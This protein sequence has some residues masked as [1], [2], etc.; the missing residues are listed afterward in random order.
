MRILLANE[1]RAGGGGVETYLA[2]LAALLASRGHEVALLHDNTAREAGPTMIATAEHW[3][4]Q[5]DGFDA[6]LERAVEW[7]PDVCFSHN[8]RRLALDEA[9]IARGRVVKMMHGYF[10]TCVSGQKAFGS[11]LQPCARTCGPSCL[12]LYGPRRCGQLRPA[13]IVA[14]YRWAARQRRLF[15]RYA[16]IVVASEHMRG[17][18]LRHGVRSG[19][20]HTIPLFAGG[21]ASVAGEPDVDVVFLGRLTP[22]KGGETLLRAAEAAAR[23]IGRRVS[24]VMAGSGPELA[25]L[26]SLSRQLA[27]EVA[28]PGWIGEAARA[29]LLARAKVA[30]LPS[31]WPEPFGLVGLEAASAG[32][33]AVAFDV[34]GIRQWLQ[35]DVNGL[36]VDV[37]EGAE[38]LGAALARVLQDARLRKRLSDGAAAAATRFTADAHLD[39][40]E[41]VLAEAA[42]R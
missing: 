6:A 34:G 23:G 20:V 40:L 21:A 3:S 26:E 41:R 31:L 13:A 42:A 33:P 1:A 19:L 30:A 5:D 2:S 9:L 4:V 32:V 36:L 27:V 15:D 35:H 37:R 12:A 10:G 16:C 22:L 24:L 25:R 28:F 7:R 39:A 14:Q 29:R 38:G 8:M 11:T 18:Y 17:E